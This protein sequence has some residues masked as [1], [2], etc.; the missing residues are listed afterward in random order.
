MRFAL[1][2]PLFALV[3]G[4]DTVSDT[5]DEAACRASGYADEG[6]V[7]ASVN[8]SRYSTPCVRG[9]LEQGALAIASLDGVVSQGAQRGIAL[10]IPGDEPDTYT[11]GADAAA[12]TYVARAAD[13]SQQADETYLA[14][15]GTITVTAV[16][17]SGATGTFSFTAQT[18][19]GGEVEVTNGR[20]DVTF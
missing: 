15:S 10:T 12:A 3:A 4:C 9:D 6:T 14:T 18:V 7:S 17:A 19:G 20:F 5:V 2:L 8:G 11:I 1:V 16:S 13:S